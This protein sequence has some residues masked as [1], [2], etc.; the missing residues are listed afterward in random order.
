MADQQLRGN[1]I[2]VFNLRVRQYLRK[3]YKPSKEKYIAICIYCL[4]KIGYIRSYNFLPLHLNIKHPEV[5]T[6]EQKTERNIHW[7]WDYFAPTS[8]GGQCNI[9]ST[10]ITSGMNTIT[11]HLNIHRKT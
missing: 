8:D 9:C 4:S 11:N 1:K 5:L 6:E 10:R 2:R 7:A 3:H